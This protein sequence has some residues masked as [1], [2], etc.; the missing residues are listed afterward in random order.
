MWDR[1]IHHWVPSSTD[2]TVLGFTGWG[3]I[4]NISVFPMLFGSRFHFEDVGSSNISPKKCVRWH[5][6]LGISADLIFSV[7]KQKNSPASFGKKSSYVFL[8]VGPS[9]RPPNLCISSAIK[10]KLYDVKLDAA[11]QAPA[12]Q[13]S[14]VH[15]FFLV[16]C[17]NPTL[18]VHLLDHLVGKWSYTLLISL[19]TVQL[20]LVL[21]KKQQPTGIQIFRFFSRGQRVHFLLNSLDPSTR[22][23]FQ[24]SPAIRCSCGFFGRFPNSTNKSRDRQTIQFFKPHPSLWLKSQAISHAFFFRVLFSGGF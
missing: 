9:S 11:P 15:D 23:A 17:W 21:N 14:F 2:V 12:C 6:L 19:S 24:K 10:K 16:W 13:N 22:N 18:I 1:W 3:D 5:I 7:S 20:F 8:F 4:W